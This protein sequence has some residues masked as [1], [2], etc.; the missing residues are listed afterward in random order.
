MKRKHAMPF[1]AEPLSSGGVRFRLW[2]P[3]VETVSLQLDG[4][5]EHPMPA[6]GQ[7]WFELSHPTA[8]AGS[9]YRFRL[10]DGLLVPDPV[11][12]SNPDAVRKINRSSPRVSA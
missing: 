2:A 9:R 3:G 11:S 5:N 4:D 8:H 1:G 10:P 12:R 7:G 6:K